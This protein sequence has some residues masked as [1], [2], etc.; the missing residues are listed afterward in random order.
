MR[1][2]HRFSP[3]LD[4]LQAR[5][6]PSAVAVIPGGS[7]GISG[8]THLVSAMDDTG[9]PGTDPSG[10]GSDPVILAPPPGTPSTTGSVC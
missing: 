3:S 9:S 6:V 4:C 7:H 10:D 1:S 8:H 5:I 2:R